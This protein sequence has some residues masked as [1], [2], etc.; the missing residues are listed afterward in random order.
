VNTSEPTGFELHVYLRALWRARLLLVAGTLAG[1]AVAFAATRAYPRQF[2][3]VAVLS[4]KTDGRTVSA[5]LIRPVIGSHVVA[6]ETVSSL[7]LD[8]PPY[9]LSP[10][11]FMRDHAKVSVNGSTWNVQV[12][13]GDATLATEAANRLSASIIR[14]LTDDTRTALAT[15]RKYAEERV[16]RLRARHEA[17]AAAAQEYWKGRGGIHASRPA[18]GAK[19]GQGLIVDA[20][21]D[22]V[23]KLYA[24]AFTKYEEIRLETDNPKPVAAI[25]APAVASVAPSSPAPA[26]IVALG[27]TLGLAT[28]T[29][30]ALAYSLV[31]RSESNPP[32]I[33]GP[34]EVRHV[35]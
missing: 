19:D 15:E 18:V 27:A 10:Q 35:R 5:E 14:V 26:V 21:L 31:R 17:L 9:A 2:S 11:A 20:E 34:S 23:T 16:A 30:F 28:A 24:D 33:S 1:A 8:E 3:A 7:R 12:T 29:A 6:A 4:P 22:A 32:A 25:L 13:L